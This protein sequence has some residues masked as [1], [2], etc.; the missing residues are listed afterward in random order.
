[1]LIL[2]IEKRVR[3][4]D[5]PSSSPHSPSALPA[6][7]GKQFK[8]DTSRMCANNGCLLPA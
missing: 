2:V 5:T 3:H 8:R 1:M 4:F 6:F 7:Y